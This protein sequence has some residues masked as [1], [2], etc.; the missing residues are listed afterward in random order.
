M[1]KCLRKYKALLII[2]L[3]SLK[4]SVNLLFPP[5][6]N[7]PLQ[8]SVS[9]P[10][11]PGCRFRLYTIFQL[12]AYKRFPSY[13]TF[14][15]VLSHNCISVVLYFTN[16]TQ[17]SYLL[18]EILNTAKLQMKSSHSL[19]L[20]NPQPLMYQHIPVSWDATAYGVNEM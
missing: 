11:A 9:F 10:R 4:K 19:Y 2:M 7:A 8:F 17:S 15:A 12:M 6:T 3:I 20:Q 13:S 1:G 18:I 5:L 14:E 16:V